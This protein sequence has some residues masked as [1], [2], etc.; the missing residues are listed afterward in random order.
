MPKWNEGFNCIAFYFIYFYIA[1][2]CNTNVQS[3]SQN[4]HI[5]LL[6]CKLHAI[7]ESIKKT[8]ANP[9][10]PWQNIFGC[11]SDILRW[12]LEALQ[13][14]C[15][16]PT[17]GKLHKHS[18]CIQGTV[19]HADSECVYGAPRDVAWE[20]AEKVSWIS[21]HKI[22]DMPWFELCNIIFSFFVPYSQCWINV[23]VCWCLSA[24][25]RTHTPWKI[26]DQPVA[27]PEPNCH[28]SS[29][30]LN[31]RARNPQLLACH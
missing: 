6:A 11:I 27:D 17:G 31:H 1:I 4:I 30:K 16:A 28:C 15:T 9:W 13:T 21:A 20:V 10:P 24:P 8:T 5:I 23:D 14:Q 12:F 22:S 18:P 7:N 29:V 2:T 3:L 26:W 25:M 19:R